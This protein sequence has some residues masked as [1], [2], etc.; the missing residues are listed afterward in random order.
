MLINKKLNPIGTE[1]FIKGRK[2]NISLAFI[3]ILRCAKKIVYRL[4]IMNYQ[5][6]YESI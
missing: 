2:L 1:L 3:T 5:K 4:W 6:D